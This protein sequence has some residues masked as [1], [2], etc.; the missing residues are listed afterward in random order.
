MLTVDLDLVRQYNQPVPRYTSYPSAVE[1]SDAVPVGELLRQVDGAKADDTRPL[2]LYVHLPFCASLCWFCGCT[3][4]ITRDPARLETY[5]RY[6]ER[7]ID[8]MA[9]RTNPRRPVVQI[10]Y[11]GG[12]PTAF[13]ATQL[14]ALTGRLR[15]RFH[16]ATDAE[17]SV[18]IDPRHLTHDQVEALAASGFT[19]ASLG[20]QDFDPAVQAAV[21]R[22]QPYEMT[23]QAI[24]WLRAAGFRSINLDLIYGLPLQTPASFAHT[25]EQVVALRPERLALFS[26][27]HVPWLK[28]AQQRLEKEA[29]VTRGE[30]KLEMLKLGL[31]TLTGHGYRYIGL[32][33]FAL[34]TDELALAQDAGTLQRNFQGYSTRAGAELMA[35]GLSAISQ[36]PA[37]Y[38]QN[39]KTL[40]EYYAAI[41]AGAPPVERGLLLSAEDR[42]RREIIMRLMCR[43]QLDYAELSRD[44]GVDFVR[45]YATELGRLRPCAADGLIDFCEHGLR[46]TP[47]GR[48]FLRNLAACF[49]A[50]YVASAQRHSRAV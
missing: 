41:N 21:R 10:H 36:T 3:T 28:P 17:L 48:L 34:P 47:K 12:T 2:S 20:V 11:G 15:D 46:V 7:E 23:R 4:V 42:R 32:D 49:D 35:F 29:G 30:V 19:R 13:S 26:Y 22:V 38:R 31:E 25:L 8:L 27:A 24:A 50:Y 33:H 6:L 45:D 16:V 39:H 5:L 18:E 37:S 44:L 9:D 14:T 43:L 40:P 1:F